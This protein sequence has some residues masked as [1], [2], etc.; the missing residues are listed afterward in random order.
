MRAGWLFA[1]ALAGLAGAGAWA[2]NAGQAQADDPAEA[3]RA[4][5]DARQQAAAASKRADKLEADAQGA[6]AAADR[7]A[8]EAAAIAARIQ[9]AEA[10]IAV[11][12]ARIRLIDQQRAALSATLARRQQPLLRLTGALQH[13]SRRPMIV[14]LLRPGS[15]NDAAHLRALLATMVP[16]VSARTAALR[17][18]IDKA[19]ALAAQ[20]RKAQGALIA[21]KTTL[22]TRRQS[23]STLETQQ[24][25][26]ARAVSGSA[27]RESERALALAEQARD[28]GG[29]LDVLDKAS[30]LREKLARLPGPIIRPARPESA[31]PS[32]ED[33]TAPEIQR[34]AD[35]T[36][37]VAGRLVSGFGGNGGPLGTSPRGI[38]IAVRAGAQV[39]APAAGRV[40][41]AGAYPGY[42]QIV[43]VEHDGGWASLITG[44]ARV[45]AQVGD[46]L[47]AGAPLGLAGAGRPVVG[48][49]LRKDGQPVNPLGQ[50]GPH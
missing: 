1:V 26:A 34:M 19:R 42:G 10:E 24:R 50:I 15:V 30:A 16:E 37:P 27:D 22:N 2:Q 21:S 48:L 4:L 49:E 31:Q 25:L 32:E 39:V 3:R 13:L 23:L 44:M 35:Y 5:D 20:E 12:E 17:Q 45:D 47:V 6:N 9:Q 43:I 8:H 36:L 7:T 29:L 40:A 33:D 18:E 14:S 38:A 11:D 41:F 46:R 28:L